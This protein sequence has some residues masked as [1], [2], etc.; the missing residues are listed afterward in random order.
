[1][2]DSISTKTNYLL[3]KI[4]ILICSFAL[5]GEIIMSFT[6]PRPLQQILFLIA[7]TLLSISLLLFIK[8]S[9][10]NFFL[11][12]TFTLIVSW[13]LAALAQYAPITWLLTLAM[14]LKLTNYFFFALESLRSQ[15]DISTTHQQITRF[16]WQLLFIRLFIGFDMIPH[17]CEKLFAG[18]IIRAE[19][20]QAFVHLGVP[21]PFYFVLLAGLVEFAGA[22]SLSCGFITR[23]GCLCL[24][25]YMVVATYLGHHFSK[26]FIWASQGGGWEYPVLW[27][28]LIVSFA[29]FGAGDFSIDR[30][31]KDKFKLPTLI[32]HLVGGRHF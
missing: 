2:L 15:P 28:T 10:M 22:L 1:M 14:L 26:G 19:D 20:V 6:H 27:T 31:L 4:V 7:F 25:T 23:L 24:G 29:V 13:R 8:R 12:S 3:S 16:E 18:P 11:L 32:K 21:Y 30:Y 17:F 5:V 9:F